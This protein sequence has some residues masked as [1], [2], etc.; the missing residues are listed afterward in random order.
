VS[1]FAVL[2]KLV[3]VIL[4]LAEVPKA[5]VPL[6]VSAAPKVT[7]AL[8]LMVRLLSAVT[9]L[10]IVTPVELPPNTRLEADVVVK[11]AGVPA[12]AGPFSVSVFVPTANPPLVRVSVPPTVTAPP[13][14]IPLARLIVRF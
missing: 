1:A 14:L 12:M 7:P 6:I 9:L 3:V 11:L 4:S 2:F 13:M 8:L 10:G 5:T